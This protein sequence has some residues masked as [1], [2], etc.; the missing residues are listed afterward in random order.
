MSN[1][2]ITTSEK[3][4]DGFVFA[5]NGEIGGTVVKS[6]KGRNDKAVLMQSEA[7]VLK[8]LGKPSAEF[9]D[10]FEVISFVRQS[11]IWVASAIGIEAVYGGVDVNQGSV[12]PFG[13]GAGRVSPENINFSAMNT[14]DSLVPT[15]LINGINN[16]FTA[17]LPNTPV[18]EGSLVIMSEGK[19]LDFNDEDGDIAGD[20]IDVS[21][22]NTIDY[23][24]G[25]VDLTL[26][27]NVGSVA[28]HITDIDVSSNIDLSDLGEDYFI[29][30]TVD[31]EE[32]TVNLGQSATN[33]QASLVTLIN[34]EFSGTP[35]SASTNFFEV[36]GIIGDAVA[37][38]VKI[39][40]PDSGASA[41]TKLFNSGG[42]EIVVY[43][44]NPTG[45]IPKYGASL[46]VG[47]VY[48]TDK[49]TTISHSFFTTSPYEDNLAVKISHIEEN[50]FT[51]VLYSVGKNSVYSEI[52]AY[53]YSLDREKD[54]FGVSLYYE[55]VFKDN[56]YLTVIVNPIYTGAYSITPSIVEFSGGYRGEEPEDSV[57]QE[58]FTNLYQNKNRY[59]VNIVMDLNGKSTL[60]VNSLI[61]TYIPASQGI[62]T[63]P[64]GT[65]KSNLITTKTAL[66]IDSR[67]IG[68][69]TGYT[70]IKDPYND[71]FAWVSNIGGVGKNFAKAGAVY[72]AES[73]AGTMSE[74][75]VGGVINDWQ[76][77]ETEHDFTDMELRNLDDNQINPIL[78]KDSGVFTIM[79]DK[80][81]Q[82]ALSGDSFVATVRLN[83]FLIKTIQEQVLEAKTFKINNVA[84]RLGAKLLID[85]FLDPI[86][87][88]GYLEDFVTVCD[89]TNNGD[90]VRLIK[91]FVVDLYIK[92]V[93]N[94]QYIKLNVSKLGAT[95]EFSDF[96]K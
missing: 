49:S 16:Q 51:L 66:G 39:E 58:L 63:L 89:L 24:S 93:S 81:G 38:N 55:D 84:S 5:S 85:D 75:G 35:F 94:N 11:P 31:S 88:A 30:I 9:P 82:L 29:K 64:F 32:K 42:E 54:N 17:T 77:V 1:F 90:A 70:K 19:R 76:I 13:N 74:N 34:A 20:D 48:N 87:G 6:A 27:G 79:G 45:A 65:P 92:N 73:P 33:T 3:S 91:N 95:S 67:D 96:I 21:G 7:D 71:S 2:R 15:G 68:F 83:K 26:K 23:V 8:H 41:L 43:G 52:E 47:Y 4:L 28:S 37:G 25:E 78:L 36:K 53:D 59:P 22:T 44:V 69:Y 18:E 62:T 40:D 61:Q 57:Y 12:T 56:A 10:V 14:Y 50:K 60:A 80:T 86:K 46:N 72:D